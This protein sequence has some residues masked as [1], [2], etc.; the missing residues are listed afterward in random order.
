MSLQGNL[1]DFSA[2][3]ILQLIG[4]QQK[5]GCLTLERA[6]E[7]VMLFVQDG[8]I[9]STRRPGMTTDDTLLKFLLEIH[10]LSREQHRGIAS[11]QKESGRDL[12]DILVNGRYL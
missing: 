9:V 3:E 4:M 11:I 8:R 10:R 7:R 12:E 6:G 2:T 1:R 5:T